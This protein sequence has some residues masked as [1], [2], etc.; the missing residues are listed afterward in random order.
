VYQK[1]PLL[2]N[3][4]HDSSEAYPLN[5]M[6]P[7]DE[8]GTKI[9]DKTV[10]P[11]DPDHR[12]AME[13]ILKAY[14]FEVAT[15]VYGDNVPE[16]DGPNEKP[17]Q[18]GVCCNRTLHC[19]CGSGAHGRIDDEGNSLGIGS[20]GFFNVGTKHHHDTYHQVLGEEEPSPPRTRAQKL[21][22]SLQL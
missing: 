21:L 10:L 13:R 19:N 20:G 8:N 16:P 18:Y 15:F 7:V 2:F 12:A 1:Y 9:P 11:D 17:G 14:A 6:N 4:E 3:V 5:L 22:Q